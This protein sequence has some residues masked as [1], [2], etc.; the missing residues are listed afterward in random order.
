MFVILIN[1]RFQSTYIVKVDKGSVEF[2]CMKLNCN[3]DGLKKKEKNAEKTEIS[4][5]SFS[6]T[7]KLEG[8]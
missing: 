8:T 1:L 6:P 5:K 7:T 4:M 2:Y 3:P